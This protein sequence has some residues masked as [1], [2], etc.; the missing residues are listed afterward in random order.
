[1]KCPKCKGDHLS[2]VVHMGFKTDTE[3]AE[4]F[5][6]DCGYSSKSDKDEVS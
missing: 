4:V 5:C 3:V 2:P 1:M 6:I